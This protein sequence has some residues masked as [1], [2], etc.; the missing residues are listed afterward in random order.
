MNS[1]VDTVT[2]RAPT[3]PTPQLRGPLSGA[4]TESGD[5]GDI[6]VDTQVNRCPAARP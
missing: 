4:P 3:P 2:I 1:I 5:D 6:V